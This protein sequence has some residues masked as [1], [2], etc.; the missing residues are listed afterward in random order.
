[1][2][3]GFH[4]SQKDVPFYIF[5]FSLSGIPLSWVMNPDKALKVLLNIILQAVTVN[6]LEL[7]FICRSFDCK[8]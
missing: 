1:M 7:A 4:L 5:L 3:Q 6:L 8:K 2:S